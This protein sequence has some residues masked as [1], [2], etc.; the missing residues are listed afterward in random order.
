VLLPQSMFILKKAPHPSAAKLWIDFILSERGQ[1]AVVKGEALISGRRVQE[2][3]AGVCAQH[4]QPQDHQGRL[5]AGLDC[6]AAEDAR[7]VDQHLQSVRRAGGWNWEEGVMPRI[8]LTRRAVLLGGAAAA[9]G[10]GWPRVSV[11]AAPPRPR[12]S[13]RR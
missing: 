1:E 12:A 5:G 9:G 6:G 2:P 3:V 10:L 11:R 13:P 4:G 7:G 8:K